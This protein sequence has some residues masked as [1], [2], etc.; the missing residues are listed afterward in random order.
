VISAA[1]AGLAGAFYVHYVRIVDPDIFLFIYTV[2]MVIMV[3]V[4]GKGTLAGP[5][6][7]G[8]I[9]GFVPD[10]LRGNAP[11]QV[12]WMIYG[13]LMIA[14]LYVLPNGIVPAVENWLRMFRSI[15]PA[16]APLRSRKNAI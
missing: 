5:V 16:L 15:L 10:L 7:G 2:T 8:L 1:M 4:G 11:P 9:F 14:I 13:A 3:I 12:Q 6:V